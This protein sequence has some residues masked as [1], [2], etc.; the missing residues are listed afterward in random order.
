M[1]INMLLGKRAFED[2]VKWIERRNVI[3]RRSN[4]RNNSWQVIGI[5]RLFYNCSDPRGNG[6]GAMEAASSGSGGGGGSV[7]ERDRVVRKVWEGVTVDSVRG[8]RSEPMQWKDTTTMIVRHGLLALFHSS[9]SRKGKLER[10]E[11]IRN[12]RKKGFGRKSCY[13]LY[14]RCSDNRSCH[15]ITFRPSTKRQTSPEVF[16]ESAVTKI[17]SIGYDYRVVVAVDNC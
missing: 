3:D 2:S 8:G 15:R 14:C 9:E 6:N 13:R 1:R 12:M 4:S 11:R 5:A 7:G 16:L 10:L 17:S